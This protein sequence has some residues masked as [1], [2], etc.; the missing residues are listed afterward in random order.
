MHSHMQQPAYKGN[1]LGVHTQAVKQHQGGPK[2]S[3]TETK[4]AFKEKQQR[5]RVV[6]HRDREKISQRAREIL[7]QE[8]SMRSRGDR[9]THKHEVI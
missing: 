1:L 9:S 4:S 6:A 5:T 8:V 2:R 7:I 3:Q